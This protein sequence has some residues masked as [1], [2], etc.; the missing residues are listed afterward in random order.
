MKTYTAILLLTA[1]ISTQVTAKTPQ[2]ESQ[3]FLVGGGLKSC[4]SMAIKNCNSSVLP[5]IRQLINVKTGSLYQ[6]NQKTIQLLKHSWPAHFDKRTKQALILLLKR[7]S[8]DDLAKPVTKSALKSR[9]KK[10]DTKKIIKTLSDPEYYL[11][12][13][14]LE[15]PVLHAKT[16]VRLKEHVKL[17][18]STNV[19]STE[20][21]ENFVQQA[22]V[23][24]GKDHPKILIITASGRDSFEAV[25]FYQAAFEQ[26]GA[27]AQWLPL[28]AT[29]NTLIHKTGDRKSVCKQLTKTRLKVQGSI[30]REFIYPDLADKQLQAC[31]VPAS[32]IENLKQADGVFINGGDQSLTLKAFIKPDGSDSEML[33]LIKEKLRN[34]YFIVGG[35]SAGTAVMSGGIF[36][37]VNTPMITNGAS[38]VAIVRGAKKNQLPVEGCQKSNMCNENLLN[39]DLTFRSKGGLGLFHWG[40]MDT[41][42]SE[43]GRQGRLAKLVL[44][45]NSRFGFGVD[46]ATALIV[47]ELSSEAPSFNVIGQGGVF[48]VEN[49]QEP[50]TNN[51]VNTHYISYQDSAKI[52][53]QQLNIKIASWK[54][55]PTEIAP[56][57]SK[58]SNVFDNSRYKVMTEILC[59]SNAD[60]YNAVDEWNKHKI[61]ITVAKLPDAAS[62]YGVLAINNKTKNYCSYTNYALSFWVVD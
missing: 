24:S 27:N 62:G 25:D 59:R 18:S 7:A 38:N 55:T 46:E 32:L 11:M 1:S 33:S 34:E 31:L 52:I 29:L 54:N 16:H 37:G 53:N 22:K 17:Q 14:L 51:S 40:I 57:Q 23:N 3:L 49:D 48:I 5:E 12:L 50:L 45:T 35:T 6:I 28:D 58:V 44:E 56:L 19:F 42:F 4:S 20:I 36:A 8:G 26:A 30:N 47:S 41:H 21:Y 39:S 9:L 15:Q 43:R 10:Y 60:E 2:K 61:N 13:D